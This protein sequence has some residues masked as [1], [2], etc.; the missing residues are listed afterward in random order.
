MNNA[1]KLVDL[2]TK[3]KLTIGSVESF[4]GGLFGKTITDVSGASEVYKGGIVCYS[5]EMKEKFIGV[6]PETI[7]EY[8]VVSWAVAQEMAIKGLEVLGV[9]ICVSFTGNA[10]P[11]VCS[12]G[13]D[14]GE[15]YMG[16]AY[17]GQ[18]WQI[19]LRLPDLDREQIRQV[20]VD[21]I[22]NAV[23]SILSR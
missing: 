10:G 3:E 8:G 12:E 6:N 18:V 7:K 15:C 9:D 19:P 2:L 23:C 13:T 21:S 20:C 1:V 17:N 16:I 14:V 11:S 22:I 4:T 5:D